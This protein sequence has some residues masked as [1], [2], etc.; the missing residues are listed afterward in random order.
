MT[1][2]KVLTSLFFDGGEIFL[3]TKNSSPLIYSIDQYTGK[4]NWV[5]TQTLQSNFCLIGDKVYFTTPDGEL[6][7][8]NRY[9]SIEK[10]RV[11]FSPVFDLNK[12]IGD[13][14]IACDTTNNV[15]AISFGDNTQIMGL[16]ILNP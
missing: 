13:Y 8:I 16:K 4:L 14:Y 5:S 6:V 3:K 12:Q 15:L 1:S 10:S 9:S 7:A 2:A 11:K